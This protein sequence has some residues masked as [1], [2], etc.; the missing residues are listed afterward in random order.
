MLWSTF[1]HTIVK[2]VMAWL[3]MTS[4]DIL[5]MSVPLPASRIVFTETEPWLKFC[6]C[7][8]VPNKYVFAEADDSFMNPFPMQSGGFKLVTS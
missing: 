8:Y 6:M 2:W 1:S 5:G 7:Q 3:D 4:Q